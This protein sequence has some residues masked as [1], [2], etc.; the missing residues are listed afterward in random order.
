MTP[1]ARQFPILVVT[2]P[3]IAK[4]VLKFKVL[5]AQAIQL[6]IAIGSPNSVLNLAFIEL[7]FITIEAEVAIFSPFKS[8]RL[9]KLELTIRLM[10]TTQLVMQQP[11]QVLI[12][13]QL[14]SL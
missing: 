11:E 6:P 14:A 2:E 9:A 1:N 10:V 8:T 4:A 12:Q 13:S 3:P 7:D 5:P